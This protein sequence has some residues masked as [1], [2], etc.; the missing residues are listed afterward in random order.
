[1]CYSLASDLAHKT[2]GIRRTK[3]E[4][5]T[6]VREMALKTVF[7]CFFSEEKRVFNFI[8]TLLL[9]EKSRKV[10]DNRRDQR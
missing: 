3:R 7:Y 8:I 10:R 2:K 9:S 1:M 4:I 6:K 5:Y